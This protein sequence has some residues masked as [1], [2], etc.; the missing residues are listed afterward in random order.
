MIR[1][2]PRSTR[3]D[4]LFP[5]TTLFRSG[6]AFGL[7]AQR[8]HAGTVEQFQRAAQWRQA[9][10]WRVAQL[11][12]VGA[13]RGHEVGTH[14]EARGLFVAPP[15]GEARAV[16]ACVAFVD[17]AAGDRAGSGIHVL[18]VAPHGEVRAVVVQLQG[19]VAGGMGEVE[20][21]HCAGRMAQACDLAQVEGLAAAVLHARSEERRVG[22]EGVRRVRYR[23]SP[24]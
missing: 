2:P 20:A 8:G 9:E 13:R 19:Q 24:A 4:T 23:W 16:G 21:D 11:P 18:V 12:A 22:K 5:Y 15:A 1:L 3:T 14:A 17:E 10:D 6:Q 7:L